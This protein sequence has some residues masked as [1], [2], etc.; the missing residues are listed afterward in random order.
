MI[1]AKRIELHEVTRGGFNI[2]NIA[3]ERIKPR[4][5]ARRV[6]TITGNV[7]AER[8]EPGKR[9]FSQMTVGKS[10]RTPLGRH[11]TVNRCTWNR[12]IKKH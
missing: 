7:T 11:V 5:T 3:A 8:I 2:T 9:I 12:I 4:V 1:A 10:T 6:F